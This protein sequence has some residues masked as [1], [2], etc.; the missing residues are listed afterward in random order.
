MTRSFSLKV[1]VAQLKE[2]AATLQAAVK[3]HE[4]RKVHKALAEAKAEKACNELI[5][6]AE[7]TSGMFTKGFGAATMSTFVDTVRKEEALNAVMNPS[8]ITATLALIG[9]SPTH[10]VLARILAEMQR[11]NA[12]VQFLEHERAAERERAAEIGRAHV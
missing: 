7:W 10:E 8:D 3:A 4:A 5:L 1:D 12:R 2:A 6:Q 9:N 11:L